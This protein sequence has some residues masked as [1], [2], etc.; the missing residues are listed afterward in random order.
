MKI[1]TLGL[2]LIRRF[3]GLVLHA[4]LCPAEKLTIGYGHTGPD[5][6]KGMRIDA[7]RAGTLLEIDC[8]KCE[9]AIDKLVKVP[10]TQG[11]YDALVS[12][13][14][15]LGAGALKSSTLLKKLNAKNYEGA[16]AEFIRWNKVGS[17]P[18]Q[19]LTARREAEQEI[20]ISKSC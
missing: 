18:Y 6:T 3:E 7:E 20:F 14:F 2:D 15:N 9:A 12:F 5:V 1:S 10:L 16:L 4:Y 17:M 8:M 13:T 19:G 11:Q